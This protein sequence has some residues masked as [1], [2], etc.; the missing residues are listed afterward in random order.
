[1]PTTFHHAPTHRHE[2][3]LYV[4]ANAMPS[5]ATPTLVPPRDVHTSGVPTVALVSL[6]SFSPAASTAIAP[7]D[8]AWHDDGVPRGIQSYAEDQH[9]RDGPWGMRG[10]DVPRGWRPTRVLGGQ[11]GQWRG[12]CFQTREQCFEQR[13][14]CFECGGTQ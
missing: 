10:E 7:D 8:S 1:L 3:L 4:P 2:A 9:A 12:L 6:L 5:E 14:W 11:I 13:E